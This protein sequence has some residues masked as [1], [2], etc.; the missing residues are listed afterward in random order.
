M[1]FTFNR[2][3][4]ND[5]T[6]KYYTNDDTYNNILT[7]VY[8]INKY[9]LWIIMVIGLPGNISTIFTISRMSSLGSFSLY[10]NLLAIADSVALVLKLTIYQ[11]LSNQVN[12]T[13]SGCRIMLFLVTFFTSYANWILV[14]MAVERLVA[15]RFPLKIQKYLSYKKSIIWNLI[16]C[17]SLMVMY[18]P[19]LWMYD[20]QINN[21]G[22]YI[23]KEPIHLVI[24]LK[25]VN[26]LLLAFIPFI[27]IVLINVLILCVIRKA[28]K[29]RYLLT[30]SSS[31]TDVS[32]LRQTMLM[33]FPSN[34]AF[35]I[36]IFP[37]CAL[38]VAESYW[39]E[40]INTKGFAF[41]YLFKEISY[42][43]VDSTHALNFYLYFLS[44]R[45]FRKQ[46]NKM[47]SCGTVV[48]PVSL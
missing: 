15:V 22:C 46:F 11:L 31:S 27:L 2:N 20:F 45:K 38:T 33:L 13:T 3:Q 7:F 28:F 1:N 19:I 6:D 18:T 21:I 32:T 41:K 42:I 34:L 35:A 26:I 5:L 47:F 14:L 17:V 39:Y 43:L 40:T 12:L 44:A 29:Q 8:I 10:V 36:L 48:K 25:W 23:N 16:V 37:A 9:Y 24:Y 30:N 4:T